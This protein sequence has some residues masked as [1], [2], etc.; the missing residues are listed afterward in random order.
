MQGSPTTGT[1]N[2]LDTACVG[3]Y[4]YVRYY[5]PFQLMASLSE[6]GRKGPT[7]SNVVILS[8]KDV[9]YQIYMCIT[10]RKSSDKYFTNV[11]A[12]IVM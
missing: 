7:K 2:R 4:R 6:V 11:F 3:S 12:G 8:F 1:H 5:S 10:Q 9:K